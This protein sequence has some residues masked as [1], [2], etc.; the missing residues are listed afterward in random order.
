MR[1]MITLVTA[2][3]MLAGAAGAA[4]AHEFDGTP[5]HLA[6]AGIVEP[7]W[8]AGHNETHVKVALVESERVVTQEIPATYE[9]RTDATGKTV[10]VL[11]STPRP[12]QPITLPARYELRKVNVWVPGHFEA[13]QAE[14]GLKSGS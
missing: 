12:I 13:T 6:A 14:S 11:D 5:L 10:E 3:V 9:T 2:L 7:S 4:Q 8:V 1:T